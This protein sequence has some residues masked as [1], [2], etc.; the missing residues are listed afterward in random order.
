M[1]GK[2]K[3]LLT[4]CAVYAAAF[5]IGLIPFSMAEDIFTA[6]ALMTGTATLV[7]FAAT[8]L[9][10]DVSVYDPYWS[11]APSVLLLAAMVR[12]RLWN[13]NAVLLLALIGVWAARLTINWYETYAGIGREDWRYAMYREKLPAPVFQLLSLLGLQMMPTLVVYLGLVSALYAAQQPVFVPL[14]AVGAAVMLSAVLLEYVSDST[15]HRFLRE[16][17]GERRTCDISVWQYT[18]HPNYLGE[19]LFWTGLFLYFA[20]LCPSIWYRGT[21]FLAIIALFLFVSIP[22]M[23]KHNAQRRDD[24]GA[25]RSRTPMLLPLPKRISKS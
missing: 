21:G 5:G 19:M 17:A 14:C 15:I 13:G 4:D 25:Y 12:F 2:Q 3:G 8:V 20:V 7:I 10:K 11:V 18:R 23:E 1:T 9:L 24:Y 16:H 6:V 22:M